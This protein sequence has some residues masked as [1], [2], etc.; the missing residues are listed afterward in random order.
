[1]ST[2]AVEPIVAP[3]RKGLALWKKIAL[4]LVAVVSAFVVVV[5]LQPSEFR[6]SRSATMAAEPATVF[7]H[8]NDF[9]NWDAWSPWAKLDPQA[10]N[11][12]EGA[13]SGTGAIFAWDGNEEVG[14]GK[15]TIV[16]S[17]PPE[18]ILLKLEFTRP[19][20]GA[21]DTEFTFAPEGAG[22]RLTWTMSGKNNFLGKFMCL[23]MN[24]DKMMGAK[25]E[26]GLGNI[27]RIV[28]QP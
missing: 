8:V 7:A 6:V 24:M 22:T 3:A 28:E 11:S 5:A 1:M 23:L 14:A 15:M 4:G 27:R 9:H 13:P 12:F 26:E 18:R 16:E 19:M 17:T 2:Q 10:K 21:C 25:F 20:A